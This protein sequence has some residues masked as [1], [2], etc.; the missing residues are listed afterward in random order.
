MT[1]LVEIPLNNVIGGSW[2][3]DW[4]GRLK[5]AVAWVKTSKGSGVPPKAIAALAGALKTYSAKLTASLKACEKAS[6]QIER[7]KQ[8]NIAQIC[9]RKIAVAARTASFDAPQ[10]TVLGELDS[11]GI[12]C[13]KVMKAIAVV[14]PTSVP[15]RFHGAEHSK[16]WS[17]AK[18]LTRKSAKAV[19]R[20]DPEYERAQSFLKCVGAMKGALRPTLEALEKSTDAAKRVQLNLRARKTAEG[21]RNYLRP[22]QDLRFGRSHVAGLTIVLDSMIK[23]LKA[24]A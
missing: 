12:R 15:L 16:A 9:A 3:K 24:A 21:Y 2:S 17:K 6:T 19:K 13:S 10:D 11:F 7:S 4:A 22:F 23:A 8:A 18:E 1:D 14:R 5:T 20:T